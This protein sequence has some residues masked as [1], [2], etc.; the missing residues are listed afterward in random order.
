[1]SQM[2]VRLFISSVI[3]WMQVGRCFSQNLIEL[4]VED[5][6]SQGFVSTISQDKN[7][8]IWAGTLNGLNR[9]DGY[10]FKTYHHV[11]ND[12]FSVAPGEIQVL[13]T[14]HTGRMGVFTAS[15]VQYYDTE[16]DLYI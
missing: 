6:L 3:L 14:D 8:Y 16:K 1:M 11:T 15:F 2:S 9:Y 4:S 13:A 10:Q 7:G 5:G 12:P